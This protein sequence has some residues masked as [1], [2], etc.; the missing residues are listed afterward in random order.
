MQFTPSQQDALNIEKHVCVTAGAGSGKTTVLVERYL[1]ILREG[2]AT[3]REI[4]AIT[5]TEKAAAEMKDRIIEELSTVGADLVSA[6][7]LYRGNHNGL[8]LLR[9]EMNTAP[10]STIHAFCSRILREFPF[11]AGVPANFGI[12]PGIDQRL[13]LQETLKETLKKIATDTTDKH[14]AELTRLLQRYGGPPEIGGTFLFYD[15]PT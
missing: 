15:G 6:H 13:L 9:D 10:I 11:Q 5:F 12:L 1:R 8:P 7:T 3:P 4:V 2:Q 14:R